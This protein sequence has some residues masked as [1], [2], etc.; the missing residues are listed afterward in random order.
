VH[1]YSTNPEELKQ[2]EEY[3]EIR[4]RRKED[5]V[6]E[7]HAERRAEHKEDIKEREE[8]R[9]EDIEKA[10]ENREKVREEATSENEAIKSERADYAGKQTIG[11]NQNSKKFQ[12]LSAEEKERKIKKQREYRHKAGLSATKA[13]RKAK[14][15]NNIRKTA[16]TKKGRD[17]LAGHQTAEL[18]SKLPE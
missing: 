3:K 14:I 7:I 16:S 2:R 13:E 1:E 18:A 8:K 9:Q 11:I 12:N 17:A 4:E 5:F 6:R 15:R 10:R